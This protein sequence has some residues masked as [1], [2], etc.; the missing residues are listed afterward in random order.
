M[1]VVLKQPVVSAKSKCALV[2]LVT[3]HPAIDCCAVFV[4]SLIEKW[5]SVCEPHRKDI[6]PQQKEK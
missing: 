4:T 1:P 3:C 2:T 5:R 6:D